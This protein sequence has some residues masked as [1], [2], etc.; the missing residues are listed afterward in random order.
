MRRP[1]RQATNGDLVARAKTILEAMNVR[2]LGARRGSRA[3]P[4]GLTWPT[5][6]ACP[7]RRVLGAGVIGGGWAA[8]LLI[9]GVDV[10]LFDP[11]PEAEQTVIASL[12]RARRAWRQ[13]TPAPL[14]PEGALS[15]HGTVAEAVTGAQLIQE[16][17]PERE[18]LKRSL[19]AQ[20]G[21]GGRPTG[22]DR[23]L[24]LRAAALTAVPR[25]GM[26]RSALWSGTR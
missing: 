5:P 24:D 15:V 22:G 4:A 23:H 13:L 3:P 21:R 10:R 25:H 11:A 8:R 14:P 16:S 18:P 6:P 2:V 7:D 12:D 19:L 9:A 20:A 17:A 26:A 1:G